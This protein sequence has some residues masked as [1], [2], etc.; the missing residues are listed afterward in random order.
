MSQP[1]L[2]LASGSPRRRELLAEA[3]YQFR[4]VA[5]RDGVEEAGLCSGCGPAELVVDL[6][7]R[8][9]G[10]VV[11][12]LADPPVPLLVLAADTVAEC[13]GQ[14]LGK[15]RDDAHAAAMMAALS[16]RRHRVYTGVALELLSG[17]VATRLASEAVMTTLRMSELS[18][19]W[20]EDYVDSGAWE[21]KA[22]GFGYQD[23]LG[24]V[25]VEAGSES[26]VVGLPMERVAELLASAGCFPTANGQ[27]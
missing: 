15:P 3:G 19:A 12:Q 22:G 16:G 4:V 8:K 14:I 18:A 10:D 17:G 13:D 1:E 26:N 5:A 27:A 25:H 21:G 24:F 11:A 20:I 7:I 6:A 23:G 2:V 9:L